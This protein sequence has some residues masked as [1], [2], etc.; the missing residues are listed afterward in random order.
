MSQASLRDAPNASKDGTDLEPAPA[1]VLRTRRSQITSYKE[2]VLSGTTRRRSSTQGGQRTISGETL[3]D[4]SSA[5]ELLEGGIKSLDLNWSIRGSDF[6]IATKQINCAEKKTRL[7][8]M[9]TRLEALAKAK[10][11]IKSTMSV[12]GKRGRDAMRGEAKATIDAAKRVQ[13]RS[14]LRPRAEGVQTKDGVETLKKVKLSGLKSLSVETPDVIPSKTPQ[15]RPKTKR[16]LSHG[17]YLGQDRQL[18][19]RL[20]KGRDKQKAI[21]M[22]KADPKENKTLP[23]PML[24]GKW[25]LEI[26]R[27][28]K[29][30]Y[31]VFSPLPPGQPKPEEW[32]KTQK[33]K[34][35]ASEHLTVIA[36]HR[37][38]IL[39]YSIDVFVGD[40]ASCWK[41]L[42]LQEVS[43]CICTP[44][45]GCD[46][47][48]QNRFMFYECDDSNCNIGAELCTNR[49]FE[50]LRRRC[51]LGGKFNIGVEV[52]KTLDRGYGVRSNRQ[53]EP[54]QIIVEYAGE[55]ITQ[56]ECDHR[57]NTRYKKNDVCA[58]S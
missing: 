7:R 34:L 12:L 16:W 42:N 28:F 5:K 14:S 13:R 58:P 20:K 8:R 40:A 52:I 4:S 9:S 57:M 33:S 44:D 18:D 29:L 47:D 49:S 26:G 2:S 48:C 3:V 22:T 1:H 19:H 37:I 39:I 10:D 53:F 21:S 15:R 54:H 38:S 46:E 56:E 41:S 31:D 11:G 6:G 51:K 24:A 36:I 45:S 23:L 27:D 50:D 55:I 35:K 30:P 25:L 43:R 32:K 17:L